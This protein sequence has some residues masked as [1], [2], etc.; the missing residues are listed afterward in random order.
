M[1]PRDLDA[2]PGRPG[3]AS[4]AGDE[5]RFAVQRGYADLVALT[6]CPGV[7][8]ADVT[9]DEEAVAAWEQPPVRQHPGRREHRVADDRRRV[10]PHLA[11]HDRV[12]VLDGGAVPLK[13]RVDLE[14]RARVGEG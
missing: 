3:R 11:A 4:I 12:L 2:D 1:A 6:V 13:R 9:N 14:D 10:I 7:V 8:E 5:A